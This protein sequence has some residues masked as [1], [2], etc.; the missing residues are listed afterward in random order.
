MVAI[1]N[2]LQ[3]HELHYKLQFMT[4]VIA[5]II[6]ITISILFT[7]IATIALMHTGLS[8][9]LARFQARSAFTGVGFTT[10]EAEKL[11]NHPVRRRIIMTLMLLGNAGIISVIASLIVTFVDTG[12][13]KIDLTIRLLVLGG[14]VIILLLLSSSNIV[15]K[16]LS[17]IISKMLK[18]YTKLN[19]RDYAGLLH[20]SEEY[21]ISELM[22]EKQDWIANQNLKNLSLRDEGINVLGIKRKSG[23][24]IG[25]PS[26]ETEILAGDLLILYGRHASFEDLDERKK[27]VHGSIQHKRAVDEQKILEKKTLESDKEQR[28]TENTNS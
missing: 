18:R 27:G 17:R 26:G 22:V 19:V 14:S 5:V 16:Q 15:D 6:I 28:K 4:S 3:V 1:D 9:Q 10:G 11:V 23:H 21:A 12:P 13:D 2:N 20:L 24:Y 25:V 7:R 8:K